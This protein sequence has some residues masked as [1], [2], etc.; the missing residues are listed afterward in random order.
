MIS[1]G[2]P[3]LDDI[4]DIGRIMSAWTDKEEVDKYLERIRNE[5]GGLTEFN[6]HFWVAKE[7]K[8]VVGIMG[9]CNPIPRILTFAKTDKSGELKILYLDPNFRGKGIGKKLLE[10]VQ[11]EA[12]KQGYKEILVQSAKRYEDTAYGF[13][14]KMGY[15]KVGQIYNTSDPLPMQVF[16]KE[17]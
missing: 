7:D 15:K 5:I 1:I 17:L 10:F 13:Y 3:T 11:N 9:L 8:K 16:E 6:L 14:E 12:V 2:K 4:E